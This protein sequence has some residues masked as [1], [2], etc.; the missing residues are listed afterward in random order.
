MIGL[1]EA[2]RNCISKLKCLPRGHVAV[3]DDSILLAF[4][5][6]MDDYIHLHLFLPTG[7]SGSYYYLD[8]E[9]SKT[10]VKR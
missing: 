5:D 4:M 7:S 10:N 9:G 2:S 1:V 6:L 8:A 3:V